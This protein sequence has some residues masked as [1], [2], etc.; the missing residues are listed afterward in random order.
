[1]RTRKL[2]EGTTGEE[3]V[4]HVGVEL[5]KF[6]PLGEEVAVDVGKLAE[7]FVEVFLS[8]RDVGVQNVKELLQTDAEIGA[9]LGSTVAEKQLKGFRCKNAVGFGKE[10]EEDADEEPFEF[11]A[12]VAARFQRIVH[13]THELR[14]FEVREVFRVEAVMGLAGNE[15]V[16]ANA[17]V[18]IWQRNSVV[19]CRRW[20]SSQRLFGIGFRCAELDGTA[21]QD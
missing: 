18:E 2:A 4:T 7:F 21:R 15:R 1:V 6:K 14:G 5:G 17:F 10:T 8:L 20:S 12:G 11:V 19:G 9:V 16:I 13:V 3:A